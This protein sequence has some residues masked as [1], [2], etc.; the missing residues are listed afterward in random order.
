MDEN[1]MIKSK[2]TIRHIFEKQIFLLEIRFSRNKFFRDKLPF[3]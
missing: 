2:K 3:E 1:V